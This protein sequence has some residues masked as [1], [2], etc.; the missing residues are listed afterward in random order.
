MRI[1]LTVEPRHKIANI[2]NSETCPVAQAMSELLG[3]IGVMITIGYD[4]IHLV[5]K[6]DKKSFTIR[7]AGDMRLW[8]MILDSLLYNHRFQ[9]ADQTLPRTFKMEIPEEFIFWEL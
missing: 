9:D 5:R 8:I 7:I 6:K 2:H 1:A 4:T 3:Y